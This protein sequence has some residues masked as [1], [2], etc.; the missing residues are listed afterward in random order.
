MSGTAR[1]GSTCSKRWPRHVMLG[2]S[3]DARL[4]RPIANAIA[5]ASDG[6]RRITIPIQ[7]A[8]AMS[9]WFLNPTSIFRL[10]LELVADSISRLDERV[11]RRAAVDFLPQAP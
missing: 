11:P 6:R 9:R 7:A 1:T 2:V 8:L 4:T 3:A 5:P 10:R